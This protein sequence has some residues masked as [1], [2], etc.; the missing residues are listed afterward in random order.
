M[1]SSLNL[2]E[3]DH[4]YVQLS[5]KKK[6]LAKGIKYCN[7]NRM[8]TNWGA[9]SNLK[10]VKKNLFVNLNKRSLREDTLVQILAELYNRQKMAPKGAHTPVLD[11]CEYVMLHGKRGFADVCEFG[12]LRGEEFPGLSR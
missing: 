6:T 1:L 12:S 11:I 3:S 2:S 5:N 4:I 7:G 8:V 10:Q 9:I